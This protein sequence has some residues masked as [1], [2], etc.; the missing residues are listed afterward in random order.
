MRLTSQTNLNLDMI[1]LAAFPPTVK[2]ER[3]L[4][5]YPQ[6][7]IPMCDQVLKEWVCLFSIARRPRGSIADRLGWPALSCIIDLAIEDATHGVHSPVAEEEI[8]EMESR[9]YKIRPFGKPDIDGE[10][11]GDRKGMGVNMRELNPGGKSPIPSILS[12][13]NSD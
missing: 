7:V 2:L 9:T 12:A 6:E 10:K 11:E 13:A 3:W 8:A 4:R 1:N 5:N